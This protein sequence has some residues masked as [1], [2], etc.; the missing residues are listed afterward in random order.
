MY[1]P[2]KTQSKHKPHILEHGQYGV[3]QPKC[4]TVSTIQHT[5]GN[6][7]NIVILIMQ[8]SAD[9]MLQTEVV[10]HSQ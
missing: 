10:L 3:S 5:G 2:S 9:R 7:N 6:K 8:M 1:A 4:V